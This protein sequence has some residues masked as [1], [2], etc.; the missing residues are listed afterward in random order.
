MLQFGIKL[1]LSIITNHN[2]TSYLQTNLFGDNEYFYT[3]QL[4]IK[5]KYTI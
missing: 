1:I 3:A 4:R 5:L 2:I